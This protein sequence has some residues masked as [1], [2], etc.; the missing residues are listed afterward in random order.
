MNE[1]KSFL[2]GA[3]ILTA[4]NIISKVLGA[5][6]KIP[7]TYILKEEGMAVFNTA[8][9]VYSIFLTFAISG[10]P[11]AASRLVAADNALGKP[12][13]AAKTTSAA[14]SLLCL[15]GILGSAALFL[16][17]SP[18]ATAMKDPAAATAIKI[19]SPSVFFVAAG[20]AYKSYFQGMGN[21]LPTAVSQVAESAIRLGV[22]FSVAFF[23]MDYSISAKAAGATAGVTTGEIT[24]T[25]ILFLI[26]LFGKKASAKKSHLTYKKIYSDI[27]SVAVP[28]LFSSVILSAMNMVDVATVR[29]GLLHVNFSV[30]SARRFLLRFSSY[31]NLFDDLSETLHFSQSGARWL[32]GAY[33]GYALTV[34]HLPLGVLAT[35]GVTIM[36]I[37]TANLATGNTDA[38]KSSSKNAITLTLFL[39][40]PFAVL[41]STMGDMILKLLFKNTAS[42]TMLALVSPCMIFLAL[43]Q[44]FSSLLYASGK[45]IEP[46]F[47]QFGG[48]LVKII[49]NILLVRI[50]ELH[51]YGAILSATISFAL[52]CFLEWRLIK[53]TFKINLKFREIIPFFICAIPMSAVAVFMKN[54]LRVLI[55]N[56]FAVCAL[57]FLISFGTYFL[58]LSFFFPNGFGFL[59]RI[60]KKPKHCTK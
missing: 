4:A 28:M 57:C 36:P 19:I 43:S 3:I 2:K 54:P 7:L 8:Q 40:I 1:Q 48:I 30:E 47:I 25:A 34:F 20:C 41:F 49:G 27:S 38:V 44:L 26:Y 59:K 16:L 53:K 42:V 50:P 24:A 21:M 14:T 11:L 29:N 46:F 5:I 39:S 37:I 18:L 33:S 6:F 58:S 9:C 22:G 17:A 32:Y 12:N 23:L 56:D 51:I 15:L 52:S 60:N 13:D 31:T 55:R 10:I 45:V 35:L